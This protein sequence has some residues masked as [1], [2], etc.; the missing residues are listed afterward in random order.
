[1]LAMAQVS[2]CLPSD[3]FS[4]ALRARTRARHL[5]SLDFHTQNLQPISVRA[6]KFPADGCHAEGRLPAETRA[7]PVGYGRDDARPAPSRR[8]RRVVQGVARA[9][10]VGN[11]QGHV[12]TFSHDLAGI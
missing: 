8:R 5:A 6:G 2:G 9:V 10:V 1:M 3:A 11:V 4:D 7:A 12:N